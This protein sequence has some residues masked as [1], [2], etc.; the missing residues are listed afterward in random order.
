MEGRRGV[1]SDPIP[2]FIKHCFYGIF[3]PFLPKIFDK[4]TERKNTVRGGSSWLGQIPN[5]YRK[6]GS[7]APLI[8]EEEENVKSRP[9]RQPMFT[10]GGCPV[11]LLQP[12]ISR[13]QQSWKQ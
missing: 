1:E 5:F 12:S 9:L 6:F 11:C 10:L 4:F 13:A 7:G 8:I 2:T 3:D